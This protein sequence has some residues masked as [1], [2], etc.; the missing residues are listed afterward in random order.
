MQQLGSLRTSDAPGVIFQF[1]SHM[2]AEH[3]HSAHQGKEW[4]NSMDRVQFSNRKPSTES[5]E[6][7][8][9]LVKWAHEDT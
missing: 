9:L 4:V 2:H 8:K 5:F 1:T 7:F 6:K 3:L